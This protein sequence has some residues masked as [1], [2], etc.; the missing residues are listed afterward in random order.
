MS[1]LQPAQVAKVVLDED[2][3][4]VEVVVPDEQLSLA[5]GRRGQNVRLA[6][7]LSGWDIDILTEDEESERRQGEFNANTQMFVDALNVDEIVGQV[8]ASEGFSDVE[9]VAYVD[10]NEVA[11][12]DG[13]DLETAQELQARAREFLDRQ[14]QD[15]DEERQALG[16]SEDLRQVPGMTTKMMVALGKSEDEIKSLEDFAG[17]VAD[18]LIGYVERKDGEVIRHEGLLK[19]FEISRE[20][21]EDMI[22]QARLAAGWV[23][24]EDLVEKE[25]VVEEEPVEQPRGPIDVFE[26]RV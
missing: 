18:D 16:V 5:I 26:A 23:T 21:A 10:E 9:E 19:D 14:E 1:A 4:R 22:I 8:L 24:E 6:S 13:F 11:S 15:L 25:V 20:E 2:R 17:C 3:N 12:I 7:Q